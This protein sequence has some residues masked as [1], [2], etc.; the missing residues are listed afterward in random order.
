MSVYLE[1][2]APGVARILFGVTGRELLYRSDPLSHRVTATDHRGRVI[3][4]FGGRGRKPGLFDTP[5]DLAFV[6]PEF[7]GE[8]LT[9][10]CTDA[11]WLAVADYGN[12]RVQVFELDGVVVGGLSTETLGD[13]IVAPCAL[14]WRAPILDVEGVDGA[15]TAIHLSAALLWN[16]SQSGHSPVKWCPPA[17]RLTGRN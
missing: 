7:F 12:R 2:P 9:P 16:A 3:A 15:R 8:R 13:H 14:T 11:V 1:H 5:L 10:D 17:L 6:R 4:A